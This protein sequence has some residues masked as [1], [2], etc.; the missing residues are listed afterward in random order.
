MPSSTPDDVEKFKKLAAEN[1]QAQEKKATE[2]RALSA[3]SATVAMRQSA[4][5]LAEAARLA[6]EQG[7]DFKVKGGTPAGSSLRKAYSDYLAKLG[8]PPD[9]K[10]KYE[11]A[12]DDGKLHFQSE[13]DAET[14][15]RDLAAKRES[16]LAVQ[17]GAGG[18]LG[19]YYLSIGDG[20]MLKGNIGPEA[21]KALA[22]S[23]DKIKDNPAARDEL[24]KLL[25]GATPEKGEAVI[26]CLKKY[27]PAPGPTADARAAVADMRRSREAAA[28]P[29]GAEVAPHTTGPTIK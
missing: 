21:V 5:Q 4:A 12:A 29:P 27:A 14:F 7:A 1:K 28:T 22:Q 16:F 11:K 24:V 6:D 18:L 13:G 8:L 25:D 17:A 10:E 26:A 20:N 2:L 19:D 3:L 9:K 15:F 23:W